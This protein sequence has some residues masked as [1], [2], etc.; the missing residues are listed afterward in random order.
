MI[1]NTR[2]K[3][4]MKKILAVAIVLI[5]AATSLSA[6]DFVVGPK[7]M[8]GDINLRGDGMDG[9][10]NKLS[11]SLAGGAFV[12][13]Q[14]TN[15][16]GIQ[17]EIYYNSVSAKIDTS[18]GWVNTRFPVLSI[19]VYAR[20]DFDIANF[21][22]YAL[23]GPRFDIRVSDEGKQKTENYGDDDNY[24]IS[25]FNSFFLGVAGG[26]GV[27]LPIGPGVLDAGVGVYFGFTELDD[28]TDQYPWDIDVQVAYGFSL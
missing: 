13:L 21:G 3:Q 18:S 1:F 2:R 14:L 23:V 15:M 8:V 27:S 26:G 9:L 19:P 22:A 11:M 25:G 20:F 5:V 12:N 17:P 4:I 16:I 24:D 6:L 7:V 28:G 10:D